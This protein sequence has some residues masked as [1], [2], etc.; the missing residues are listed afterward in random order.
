MRKILGVERTICGTD[1]ETSVGRC[2][3]E[4]AYE[5]DSGE[6]WCESNGTTRS[7]SVKIT[8]TAG[9]VILKSPAVPVTE[10]EDVTL[11][12]ITKNDSLVHLAEFYKDGRPKDTGYNGNI[13]IRNVS[14]ADEG[15]YKCAIYEVGESPESWL[16]VREPHEETHPP[17]HWSSNVLIMWALCLAAVLLLLLPAVIVVGLCL[18]LKHRVS[19]ATGAAQP[20]GE[21]YSLLATYRTSEE[22]DEFSDSAASDSEQQYTNEYILSSAVDEEEEALICI[23]SQLYFS[24]LISVKDDVME[25]T[26][27]CIRLTLTFSF[28][29]VGH[30][31][32]NDSQENVF[33]EI[34]PTKLQLFEYKSISFTCEGFQVQTGLKVMRT[35]KDKAGQCVSTWETMTQSICAIKPAYKTDSGRYWCESE[36]GERSNT[37]NITI[38]GSAVILESPVRPVKEG[39]TVS[40]RCRSKE[41]SFAHVADFY[42]DGVHIGTG[43]T[44]ET[45]IRSVSKSHE[46][47]YRCSISDFGESPQSWLAVRAL[48]GGPLPPSD[49]SCHTYLVLRTV[50]TVLM[51]ALLLVLVSLLHFGKLK[52]TQKIVCICKVCKGSCQTTENKDVSDKEQ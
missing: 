23:F 18:C 14:K 43:S 12:C 19:E 30:V 8:V 17:P 27:L 15:L 32:L 44:G 16:A 51:V 31:H 10:G 29:L 5:A 47:L 46:G 42:K 40:L 26:S 52:V 38:T 34:V 39:D 37:V 11:T 3:I 13:M 24:V 6:Y 20:N 41:T 1:W 35:V 22:A 21:A 33:A 49:H 4:H 50:F 28:L 36:A 48:P 25:I 2:S 9:S 7:N 45:S